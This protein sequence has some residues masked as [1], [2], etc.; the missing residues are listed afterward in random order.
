[1][2]D[3]VGVIII[4]DLD[5]N[6]SK[7][8]ATANSWDGTISVLLCNGP[9]TYADQVVYPAGPGYYSTY[10]VAGD[11]DGD[12][13]IDLAIPTLDNN[14]TYLATVSVLLNNGD[15]T[16]AGYVTYGVDYGPG[17][18]VLA[19]FDDDGDDDLA[20]AHYHQSGPE[21]SV[22]SVLLNQGNGTFLDHVP[23]SVG[24]ACFGMAL[25][26][27]DGDEDFDLVASVN[28]AL[29]ILWNNGS[30]AFPTSTSFNM[31]TPVTFPEIGD[32]DD[33]GDIDIV[34]LQSSGYGGLLLFTNQGGGEFHLEGRFATGYA[35]SRIVIGDL[36]ADG[37][38][39]VA[40][41]NGSILLDYP[42]TPEPV[43]VQIPT[44]GPRSILVS[45]FP[46]PFNPSTTITFDVPNQTKASLRVFAVSGRLL[47]TLVSGEVLAE[48]RHEVI[49][50]GRDES[51]RQAS[52]G[53]YFYRLQA[54]D[55]TATRKIM[56]LR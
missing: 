2:G 21:T 39:D 41:G 53:V 19:D 11:L 46:N 1:M 26:D 14:D 56:L 23:Y 13:D 6:G 20:V 52:S 3:A 30:G 36:D 9:G 16:F 28:Y 25:G 35:P 40:L 44:V 37:V 18:I 54:G 22:I 33:D 4:A 24:G 7:D 10:L 45:S 32:F 27:F 55:F 48:G 8:L 29:M 15:G 17:E 31:P 42:S 5:G 51:G 34:A 49:W 50:D 12:E 43:S 47:R 38:A